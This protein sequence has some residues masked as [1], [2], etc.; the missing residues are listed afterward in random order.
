MYYSTNLF[1]WTLWG[2][3]FF[4]NL[5]DGKPFMQTLGGTQE[6]RQGSRG[7]LAP[8]WDLSQCWYLL[9]EHY[10]K[11]PCA[12]KNLCDSVWEP[13][14]VS[15]RFKVLKLQKH[16][17]QICRHFPN[18]DTRWL[19]VDLSIEIYYRKD[20]TPWKW[21]METKTSCPRDH[22]TQW[23]C[24]LPRKLALFFLILTQ[25]CQVCW[26]CCFCDLPLLGVILDCLV[27]LCCGFRSIG[28]TRQGPKKNENLFW[29]ICLTHKPGCYL[30]WV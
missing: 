5:L 24:L 13:F 18:K 10:Q 7:P 22:S 23:S 16:L 29:M 9:W 3:Y 21:G 19:F 17:F 4:K 12:T 27:D 11:K 26:E 20:F 6:P 1:K 28:R 25:E 8:Q 14:S 30:M 2:V 15:F